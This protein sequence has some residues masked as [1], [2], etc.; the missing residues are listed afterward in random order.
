MGIVLAAVV[1]YAVRNF[2]DVRDYFQTIPWLRFPLSMFFIMLAK[3][4]LALVSLISVQNEGWNAPYW[5]MFSFY[6]VTQLGKYLPG[7]IWH[8]VGRFGAYKAENFDT[9]KSLKAMIAE[10]VWLISSALVTGFV[11]LLIFNQAGLAEY[12]ITLTAN[13]RWLLVAG[14]LIAWLAAMLLFQRYFV[15]TGLR[16]LKRRAG[17]MALLLVVWMLIGFSYAL[18]FPRVQYQSIGLAI[19]GFALSW[20]I[21]YLAVFA[22]GG[23]GVR[24]FMLTLL[25]AATP[26]ANL[27]PILAGVHRM[28]WL[29]AEVLLGL[30]CVTIDSVM[31]KKDT[32]PPLSAE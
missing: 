22:P 14:I 5:K 32:S 11:Y 18:I 19:G 9:K 7:G 25:F 29:V 27:S 21:G 15:S 6:N 23:L 3:A 12:G 1:L 16:N 4:L 17:L 8:F 31:K 13:V 28:V 10:N 24:E 20:S 30:T 2:A 26:Y